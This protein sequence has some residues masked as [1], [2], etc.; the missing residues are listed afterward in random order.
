MIPY[1]ADRHDNGDI[2]KTIIRHPLIALFAGLGT[3]LL[4]FAYFSPRSPVE[5]AALVPLHDKGVSTYYVKGSINGL[6]QHVEFLVD[7]GA[8]Y[9]TINE[10]TLHQLEARQLAT[11]SR[12]L[13]GVLADGSRMKVPVYRISDITLGNCRL[14]GIEAAVFPGKTRFLLGMNALRQAAPFAFMTQPTPQLALGRC[15]TTASASF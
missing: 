12:N 6:G 4:I 2:M 15:A 1:P 5:F 14:S 13:Y 9:T 8:G 3:G 7:T 10:H 11:Y